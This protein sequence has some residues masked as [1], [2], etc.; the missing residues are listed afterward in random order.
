MW[1]DALIV[2]LI[3]TFFYFSRRSIRYTYVKFHY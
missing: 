3:Y 1:L 2:V